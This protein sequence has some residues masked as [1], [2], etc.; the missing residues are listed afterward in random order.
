MRG[1]NSAKMTP[2]RLKFGLSGINFPK[3]KDC[4]AKLIRPTHSWLLL[5]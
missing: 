2:G 4:L 5:F 3:M 1:I